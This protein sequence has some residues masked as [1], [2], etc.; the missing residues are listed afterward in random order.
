MSRNE[1]TEARVWCDYRCSGDFEGGKDPPDILRCFEELPD[2]LR[3]IYVTQALQIMQQVGVRFET[4]QKLVSE[5][6]EDTTMLLEPPKRWQ[7]GRIPHEIDQIDVCEQLTVSQRNM[8][9]RTG[10]RVSHR[11][12]L[13]KPPLVQLLLQALPDYSRR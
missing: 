5:E 7:K 2:S 13:Q 11:H 3:L 10:G 1:N 9:L 6:K 12:I 8:R 4:G